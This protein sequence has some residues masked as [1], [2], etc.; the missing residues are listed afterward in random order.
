V[1][2]LRDE[3]RAVV[4]LADELHDG[5]APS[6]ATWQALAAR[7]DAEQL[8]ELLVL[9]GYYHAIAYVIAGARLPPEPWARRFAAVPR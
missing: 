6:E 8:L 7:L 4:T 5:A 9:C 2:G 1:A 3:D